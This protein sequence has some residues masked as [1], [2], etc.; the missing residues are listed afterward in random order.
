MRSSLRIAAS[1]LAPLSIT[2]LTSAQGSRN[3]FDNSRSIHSGGAV[4]PVTGS[5]GA[6]RS[7][8]GGY[9]AEGTLLCADCHVMHASKQHDY[10]GTWQAET[11]QPANKLL[12]RLDSVDLCLSCH[13]GMAGVPD[14][15]GVDVNGLSERSAG[16]FD[17]VDTY[18]PRGHDLGRGL[19]PSPD[20]YCMRCHWGATEPKV[21]C[22]DCHNPHG[23]H[24]PRNL[25]WAS[26]PEGTPP[27]GIF[28][29]PGAMGLAK[30]ERDNVAYGTL[31]SEILREPTNMCLDCHH[32]F[33]G[34][35]YNN[36]AGSGP[37][38][39]HPSYESE[40]GDP[41][42]IA[43]GEPNGTTSPAHWLGGVGSGFDTPRVPF[44]TRGA[45]DFESARFIAPDTNG[46]FCFSCHKAHGSS[47]AFGLIWLVE[48]Q[49]SPRGCDQCHNTV[50]S[51]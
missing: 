13:D 28:T 38:V 1:L 18:N 3:A 8:G 43:Q 35:Y 48:D 4:L 24:N 37:H 49:L 51:S 31:D 21:T 44:V 33:T 7:T 30:Y 46:V 50:G 2:A 9:H 17:L 32:V 26:Y 25:Q 12:K 47:N 34:A 27:L 14:V 11:F 40:R 39:L 36:P 23:N 10:N 42:S 5:G 41:N 6:L 22:I 16:H 45:I 29:R 15:L 20:Q 19:L